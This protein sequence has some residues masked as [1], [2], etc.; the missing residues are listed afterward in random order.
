MQTMTQQGVTEIEAIGNELDTDLHEAIAKIPAFEPSQ[1]GKIIDVVQ[2][3]Y[4]LKDKV[5][6]FAK[7]VVGE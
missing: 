1:K 5:V 7:V 2:K 6:R 4:K 3:G